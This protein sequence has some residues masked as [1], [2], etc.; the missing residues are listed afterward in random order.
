MTFNTCSPNY[1][2][3]LF[4]KI[5]YNEIPDDIQSITFEDE[6]NQNIDKVVFPNSLESITFGR[7]F[8]QNI[9]KVLFPD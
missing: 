5:I 3:V 4:G 1:I 8:N 6:F 2:I 9:D 7:K